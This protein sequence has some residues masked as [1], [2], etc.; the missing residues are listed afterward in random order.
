[1]QINVLVPCVVQGLNQILNLK[2]FLEQ[3][4]SGQTSPLIFKNYNVLARFPFH[5]LGIHQLFGETQASV[6]NQIL[7][8]MCDGVKMGGR[9]YEVARTGSLKNYSK[10]VFSFHLSC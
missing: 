2:R 1:M 5:Y 7:I 3:Y 10:L 9:G 4:Q 8:V 6:V